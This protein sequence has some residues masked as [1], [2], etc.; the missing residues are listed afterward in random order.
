MQQLNYTGCVGE[1]KCSALQIA[2]L[3]GLRTGDFRIAYYLLMDKRIDFNTISS[4]WLEKEIRKY[5]KKW[6]VDLIHLMVEN[7]RKDFNELKKKKFP[8]HE[9]LKVDY[10]RIFRIHFFNL[11]LSLFGLE[12]IDFVCDSISQLIREILQEKNI[13]INTVNEKGNTALMIAVEN[14]YLDYVKLLMEVDGIDMNIQSN[15]KD[16]VLHLAV[17]KKNNLIISY[18]NPVPGQH[19]YTELFNTGQIVKQLLKNKNID[20]NTVNENG[21]TALI[22]AVENNNLDYVKLLMEDDAINMNI[23][24]SV[25]LSNNGTS[26][27]GSKYTAL[28]L[29][30]K[31][32]NL[33]I[34]KQL[35]KNKNID[36]S[37]LDSENMTP[38]KLAIEE[39]KK[40][41]NEEEIY[42]KK[43]ETHMQEKNFT[44]KDID[45][46]RQKLEESSNIATRIVTLK[47]RIKN[48][49]GDKDIT[50]NVEK[51]RQQLKDLEKDYSKYESY[52]MK[53]FEQLRSRSDLYA[54]FNLVKKEYD[55]SIYN[56]NRNLD[57]QFVLYQYQTSCKSDICYNC[58]SPLVDAI[59]DDCSNETKVNKL[60]DLGIKPD[61][62]DNEGSNALH[63]IIDRRCKINTNLF[64][65]ILNK[66]KDV[67]AAN[68]NGWTAL[69]IAVENN[70]LDYVKLLI[71]HKEIKP[72]IQNEFGYTAL[73]F[74]AENSRN[75]NIL[76]FLLE[77]KWSESHRYPH[78]L[79]NL[80]DKDGNT[81]LMVAINNNNN[82][83]AEKLL[84]NLKKYRT[85]VF[86]SSNQGT[87]QIQ[88]KSRNH[89]K[90][91][92]DEKVYGTGIS[93]L[94]DYVNE[95]NIK[96]KNEKTAKDLAKSKGMK[97]FFS[98][99]LK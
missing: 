21:D 61:L 25:R 45:D 63:T 8:L 87:E 14:N 72:N 20:L 30:I 35:L 7:F 67:N 93:D 31:N 15:S 18:D 85:L 40:L 32:N 29:A 38:L 73:H 26:L 41:E 16:T 77:Y 91:G 83:S 3:N 37:L 62:V 22:I 47:E 11:Q 78:I 28:H 50:S 54:G 9:V 86:N 60:L 90:K 51:W 56:T 55:Q 98:Y 43:L 94:E 44:K 95:I 57:C 80:Q 46:F 97:L 24:K 75:L 48:N 2:I 76:D 4:D 53:F 69:M 10:N 64:Q 66:I 17:K 34:L 5:D 88:K 1:S 27:P 92:K 65:K 71:N 12:E 84:L 70:N 33:E 52:L 82:K 99:S 96:N 39:G 19:S 81:P 23:Q 49:E 74:A 68:K 58:M 42:K 36:C 79:S 59:I 6:Y 89:T 13:D